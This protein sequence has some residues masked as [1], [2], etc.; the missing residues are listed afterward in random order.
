MLKEE[1]WNPK[2]E[3]RKKAWK[4]LG[5]QRV[6]F[7]FWIALKQRLLT[8]AERARCGIAADPSCPMCGYESE[9]ILHIIRDCTLAKEV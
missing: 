1:T 2:D 4:F 5:L 3:L 9:D 6:R 7:F 8:N